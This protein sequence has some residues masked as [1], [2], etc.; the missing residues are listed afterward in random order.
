MSF[1]YKFFWI[2]CAVF[3]IW[4]FVTEKIEAKKQKELKAAE[5]EEQ[6]KIDVLPSGVQEAWST[7]VNKRLN[8][9][10]QCEGSSLKIRSKPY[11]NWSAKITYL[12]INHPYSIECNDDMSLGMSVSFQPASSEDES[13]IYVSLTGILNE[14]YE[15]EPEFGVPLHSIAA[16]RLNLELCKQVADWMAK[17]TSASTQKP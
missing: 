13:G 9:E 4:Y 15:D 12:S 16:E 2:G 3:V 14:D 5:Y 11:V 8:E 17:I 10:I 6:R 7:Y 1:L